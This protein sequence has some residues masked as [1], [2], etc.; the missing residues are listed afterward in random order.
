MESISCPLRSIVISF[1]I[2]YNLVMN[3]KRSIEG[4]AHCSMHPDAVLIQ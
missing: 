4:D 2:F 1:R 3:L